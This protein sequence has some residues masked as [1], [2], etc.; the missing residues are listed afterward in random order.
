MR[1]TTIWMG[2]CIAFLLFS[3][4]PAGA[5]FGP[6]FDLGSLGDEGIHVTGAASGDE[7]GYSVALLSDVN[8]DQIG[9]LLIGAPY[10]N[11]GTGAVYIVYGSTD[12]VSNG[13][14]DLSALGN[15]GVVI[16]GEADGDRLGF[17]VASLGDLNGDG[18][19]DFILGAPGHDGAGTDAGRCYL[20][21]GSTGFPDV[22][23]LGSLGSGGV[24]LDGA[25]DF[26]SAGMSLALA[27]DFGGT[28]DPDF[29]VGAPFMDTSGGTAAG[30][31]YVIYWDSGM[32][33]Q[34][35]LGALGTR[36][37]AL[38]GGA[39]LENAGFSVSG[40]FDFNGD[41]N[42]DVAV[43]AP[44][45]SYGAHYMAGR[46]Y[47]VFGRS[48]FSSPLDLASAPG[49]G[50]GSA[51]DGASDMEEAGYGVAGLSDFNT[52]GY[53]D[54]AV[55]APLAGPNGAMSGR[56]YVVHG[57]AA[58]PAVLDLGTLG[59]EGLTLDGPVMNAGKFG[60]TVS[61]VG[62]MNQ[63]GRDDLAVG[64]PGASP[65]ITAF[66]G[67]I[68]LAIGNRFYEDTEELG[69]LPKRVTDFKGGTDGDFSGG[70]VA[71]GVDMDGDGIEDFV[72]GAWGYSPDNDV[73]RGRVF[74]LKGRDM[75]RSDWPH[76]PPATGAGT[77]G[78]N[79]SFV[80]YM[81]AWGDFSSGSATGF[82]LGIQVDPSWS[83]QSP[84]LFNGL[85]FI[86]AQ[87]YPSGAH[88]KNALVWPALVQPYAIVSFP[89][90]SDTG[91][92]LQDGAM[93]SGLPSGVRVYFQ[94]L[95]QNPGNGNNL[96][97]TN[98]LCITIH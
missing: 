58:P 11:N 71:G 79:M 41:G 4:L 77:Q 31:A 98:A 32:P 68:F 50:Y 3:F 61:A 89:V 22:L 5:A 44:G 14:L 1:V 13:D 93:P 27:G 33:A 85:L 57:S 17:A 20:V 30:T 28:S 84:P 63:D 9:D 64:L 73:R 26:G 60:M 24:I 82:V 90:W 92:W 88:L 40:G 37:V 51:F 72:I 53:G 76:S 56:V 81:D 7:A 66:A 67:E 65:G 83:S 87:I 36:G 47:V 6:V 52:D 54:L 80:P 69:N 97:A 42:A 94:E 16:P 35:D 34:I 43:G 39:F 38:E 18:L 46:S 86:S 48:G 78:D 70:A 19:T 12:L 21:Y 8:G 55:S 96:A 62:D 49:A 95:W 29:I 23:D 15:K 91:Q 10:A 59:G 74:L 25:A 75:G 2:A 45:A